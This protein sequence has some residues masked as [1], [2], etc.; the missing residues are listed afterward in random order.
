MLFILKT[1]PETSICVYRFILVPRN[2]IHNHN[3]TVYQHL[4][5][6]MRFEPMTDMFIKSY[7]LKIVPGSQGSC[8]LCN[9]MRN[10][11]ERNP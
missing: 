5:R 11:M 2:H 1:E 3:I 4:L 8:A 7:E 9:P 6:D 10:A